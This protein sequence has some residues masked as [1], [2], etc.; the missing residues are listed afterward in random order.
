MKALG[1]Y[2][3]AAKAYLE[4]DEECTKFAKPWTRRYALEAARAYVEGR[5]ND[6]ASQILGEIA[7]S[8][9]ILD[10]LEAHVELSKMYT[11]EGNPIKA[12]SELTH[13]LTDKQFRESPY[14]VRAVRV[15]LK[16]LYV[17]LGNKDAADKIEALLEDK[18]CPKCGSAENVV[19]ISYGLILSSEKGAHLGGCGIEPYS[20]R[21]WCNTDGLAF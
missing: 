8:A 9:E 7:Q 4:V 19:P 12:E 17:R 13:L 15:N 5:M 21:W 11:A 3:E 14:M 16:Q 10:R 18:H 2:D 20:A 1:R 6:K